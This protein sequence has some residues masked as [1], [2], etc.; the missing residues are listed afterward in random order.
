MQVRSVPK[1]N[2]SR[3]FDTKR[4]TL[5]GSPTQSARGS[6]GGGRFH[7]RLHAPKHSSNAVQGAQAASTSAHAPPMPTPNAGSHF[8]A[9]GP[10][11]PPTGT[12]PYDGRIHTPPAQTAR[13]LHASLLGLHASPSRRRG[14]HAQPQQRYKEPRPTDETR[15]HTAPWMSRGLGNMYSKP[16]FEHDKSPVGHNPASGIGT[17]VPKD[18]A[19]V[20]VN[21]KP[22]HLRL[23]ETM[24]VPS[25]NT[26]TTHTSLD[27]HAE[28]S[29][30]G[31]FPRS[32]NNLHSSPTP[33]VRDS[34]VS[35]PTRT[36][37]THWSFAVPHNSF[38]CLEARH[39]SDGTTGRPPIAGRVGAAGGHARSA[40][41][42]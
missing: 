16:G 1:Q 36:P 5:I 14:R 22:R 42:R 9:A 13:I 41:R 6:A 28:P 31:G 20:Q 24:H 10:H 19:E 26:S 15:S 25:E 7:P 21:I 32:R 8:P 34:G 29:A 27:A 30:Q 11:A 38:L 12:S 17:E 4:Y 18:P 35:M 3:K 39:T 37:R 2:V 33:A 40:P 23:S